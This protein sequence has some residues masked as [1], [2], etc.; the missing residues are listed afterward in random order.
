MSKEFSIGELQ[1][2][3]RKINPFGDVISK[4]DFSKI[5][6]W[7]DTGNYHLNAV[8]SGDLFGGIPN[9]RTICLAGDSGTGKTFLLLNMVAKAQEMGYYVVY[10][11]TEGAVDVDNI[12]AFGVDPEKFDHQP[13]SDIAKFRTSITTLCKKLMEAKEKGFKT[14][15]IFIALDSLG[16]LATQKEIDDAISGNTAADMTR[17]KSIRSLFRIITSDLTG[18]GIPFV[19]TNHTYASTGMFPTVNLSGGGGLI[20]SASVILALSKAQIKEGTVQT[21]IIVTVKTLKN[22]F[23]KPIPIKFHIRWDKGMNPYIGMEEYMNWENCGIQKGNLITDKEYEKMND[24]DKSTVH[25]FDYQGETKYFVPRETARNYIVK[26]LGKG[27]PANELFTPEV[28]TQ[29]VLQLINEK[30][31]KPKFSYG[32]DSAEGE[33]EQIFLNADDSNDAE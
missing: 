24:K 5:T 22:R 31:I 11:D 19:F 28:W 9:N 18:L 3:L 21:G 4:S 1:K 14:P 12:Q 32:I 26:H 2:E 16:M 13:V 6:E 29:E 25:T 8:F 30:C 17:A 23:G 10:Y 20:Y 15:K 33:V 7:I 27:I